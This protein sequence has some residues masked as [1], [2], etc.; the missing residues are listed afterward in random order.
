MPS[1]DTLILVRL[2]DSRVRM[3]DR[4]RC[5]SAT[6]NAPPVRASLGGDMVY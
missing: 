1:S 4:D 6:R 5:T 3:V 2:A